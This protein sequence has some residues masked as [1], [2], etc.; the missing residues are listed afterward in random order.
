[1]INPTALGQHTILELYDCLPSKLDDATFL[2]EIMLQGANLANAT[3]VKSYF[4]QFSPIGISGSIIIAE[5]HFNIH[6]W[7][8]HGYAAIDL[9][10]CGTELKADLAAAYIVEQLEC[11]R[12]SIKMLQRGMDY[13]ASSGAE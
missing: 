13:R 12:H 6:T 5:S 1:M 11:K 3:I 7:P 8:E 9:F 4:H 2:E 10:T